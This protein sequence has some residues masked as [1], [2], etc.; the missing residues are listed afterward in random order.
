MNERKFDA[1]DEIISWVHNL[2]YKLGFIVAI[3]ESDTRYT[4]SK[5]NL[6]NFNFLKYFKAK[7][8][9]WSLTFI[10]SFNLVPYV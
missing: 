6:C 9:I 2:A 8:Y 1:G 7:L 3:A 5:I 10:L 4:I